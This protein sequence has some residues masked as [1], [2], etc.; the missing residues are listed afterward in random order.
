M[1]RWIALLLVPVLLMSAASCDWEELLPPDSGLSSSGTD[2]GSQP[3]EYDPSR[4]GSSETSSATDP[5]STDDVSAEPTPSPTPTSTPTPPPTPTPTPTPE[6]TPDVTPSPGETTSPNPTVGPNE[7]DVPTPPPTDLPS[8]Q[9]FE[10]GQGVK[11]VT[12]RKNATMS[13]EDYYW[14]SQLTAGEKQVYDDIA[15]T[16]AAYG[17]EVTLSHTAHRDT[18]N[19]VIALFLLDHPE[20]FWWGSTYRMMGTETAVRSVSLTLLYTP[21]EIG[22]M[23]KQIDSVVN[24]ILGQLPDDATDFEAERFFHDWL[25]DTVSYRTDTDTESMVYSLY[26]ALVNKTAVC[27]GYVEAFQYLC[28]KVGIPC[29]GVTG[30]ATTGGI[31]GLHKWNAVSVGGQWY[32]VDVT[33]DDT[34]QSGGCSYR[35]FNLTTEEMALDHTPGAA[36]TDALP[37]CT[38]TAANFYRYYGLTGSADRLDDAFLR[39]I[40]LWAGETE[41]GETF[42]VELKALPKEE[43]A[44]WLD[45]VTAQGKSHLQGLLTRYSTDTGHTVT[46]HAV[47]A[48]VDGVVR[49]DLIQT[50]RERTEEI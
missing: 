25:D 43:A 17:S 22:I 48:V 11:R 28:N 36:L 7:T 30:T 50:D 34:A 21:A 46:I 5:V 18:V 38:A 33:W 37:P 8:W 44:T 35:Y 24:R 23:K 45:A 20:V 41:P 12:I 4:P 3:G 31:A 16:A 6:E 13:P 26:G 10:V 29:L 47:Y 32:Y 1:K 19:K 39:A 49:F 15:K 42:A 14:R 2:I 9:T 40:H 27:E